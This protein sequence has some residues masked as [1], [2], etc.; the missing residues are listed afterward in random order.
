[1]ESCNLLRFF[2][3]LAQASGDS[4]VAVIHNSFTFNGWI[5]FHFLIHPLKD[6]YVRLVPVFWLLQRKL[7][8]A[9]MDRFL[10]KHKISFMLNK[11]K[12]HTNCMFSV[13]INCQ[14]PEWLY[15]FHIT[16]NNSLCPHPCPH[17][18]LSLFRCFWVGYNFGHSDRYVEVQHCDFNLHFFDG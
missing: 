8:W 7:V 9:F 16:T 17:M 4:V 14:F 15:H 1:M 12:M 13:I 18:M 2:F 11:H 6:T 10:Y 5:V 3:H